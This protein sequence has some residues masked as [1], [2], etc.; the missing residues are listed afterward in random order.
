MFKAFEK[1]NE[2]IIFTAHPTSSSLLQE[3]PYNSE[4]I[5]IAQH[6]PYYELLTCISNC[7]YLI[8]DSGALQREAYYLSKRCIIRQDTAFWHH[9]VDIGAHI[10]TGKTCNDIL[11]S[12]KHME[13][14]LSEQYPYTDS[15]GQGN[16]VEKI[17]THLLRGDK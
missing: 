1:I 15:L 14:L 9:L 8:T 6:I 16:A 2:N 7:K 10:T 13:E 11:E 12:M 5:T 17:I 4:R 3:I